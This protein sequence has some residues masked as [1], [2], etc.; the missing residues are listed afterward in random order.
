VLPDGSIL[1]CQ[2]YALP[3]RDC[4]FE[5]PLH[6]GNTML[7]IWNLNKVSLNSFHIINNV[8]VCSSILILFCFTLISN[9]LPEFLGHLTAKEVGGVV[10]AGATNVSPNVPTL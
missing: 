3:T 4:L 2:Y 5:D 7:K 8:Y 9:S 1:R 10:K 6:D